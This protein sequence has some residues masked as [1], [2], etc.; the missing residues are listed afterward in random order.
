[1]E[2]LCST[3]MVVVFFTRNYVVPMTQKGKHLRGKPF[4]P[5]GCAVVRLCGLAGLNKMDAIC[6]VLLELMQSPKS[7]PGQ[8]LSRV[9]AVPS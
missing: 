3:E 2:R 6:K 9:M 1:M 4:P 8:M 7:W 5:K